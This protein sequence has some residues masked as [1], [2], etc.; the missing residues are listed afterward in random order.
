MFQW[1]LG[2]VALGHAVSGYVG[3]LANR[4]VRI[5]EGGMS[6]G[7]AC[8][9]AAWQIAAQVDSHQSDVAE[10]SKTPRHLQAVSTTVII[11]A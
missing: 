4:S 3:G 8:T 1:L 5:R 9:S 2:F 11:A 6:W 7:E 10:T